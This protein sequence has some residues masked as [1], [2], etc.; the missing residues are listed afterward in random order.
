MEFGSIKS[1][2]A[3]LPFTYVIILGLLAFCVIV[4]ACIAIYIGLT[5]MLEPWRKRRSR[6][7][8]RK[9]HSGKE[10]YL[11]QQ[12]RPSP[13]SAREPAVR[14]LADHRREKDAAALSQRAPKNQ[15]V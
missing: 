9:A 7:L 5:A 15:F 13:S 3:S 4:S 6:R 12:N 1:A 8:Q 14:E 10:P 11:N 2:I